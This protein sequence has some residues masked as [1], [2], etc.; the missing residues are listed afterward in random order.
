[1]AKKWQSR[2]KEQGKIGRIN[3]KPIDVICKKCS[4][5]GS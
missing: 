2:I 5:K 3:E 1:M 4:E